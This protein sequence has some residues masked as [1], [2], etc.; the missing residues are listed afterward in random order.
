M[1]NKQATCIM[2]F[3]IIVVMLLLCS[4]FHVTMET[5][6]QLWV[7]RIKRSLQRYISQWEFDFIAVAT[8]FLV[9]CNFLYVSVTFSLCHNMSLNCNCVSDNWLYNSQLYQTLFCVIVI[10]FLP[11]NCNLQ[12]CSSKL[13]L[14]IL[15]CNF[16]S[17]NYSCISH[18]WLYILHLQ[19]CFLSL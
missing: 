15:Q 10:F 6:F 11:Y 14:N 16:I 3:F 13:W 5:H 1:K 12:L 9:I 2:L 4:A 18:N 17:Y 19:L 7:K 8:L